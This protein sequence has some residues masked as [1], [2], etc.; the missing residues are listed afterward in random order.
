MLHVQDRYALIKGAFASSQG[1]RD[2]FSVPLEATADFLCTSC[3]VHSQDSHANLRVGVPTPAMTLVLS[4]PSG[5][6]VVNSM[7]GWLH[8]F[9]CDLL[10][11][12]LVHVH[13][14]APVCFQKAI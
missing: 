9:C 10:F 5:Q 11:L 6:V 12:F 2:E 14:Q 13:D 4:V 8:C 7:S 1:I 3:G